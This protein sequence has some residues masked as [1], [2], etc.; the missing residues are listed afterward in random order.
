M[1][2]LTTLLTIIITSILLTGCGYTEVPTSYISADYFATNDE[3]NNVR[4]TA[5]SA[6]IVAN[7]NKIELLWTN[8]NPVSNFDSQTINVKLTPGKVYFIT[9]GINRESEVNRFDVIGTFITNGDNYT[10][11]E[12]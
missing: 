7:A 6:G 10:F 4:Q 5:I 12:I 9:Y 8:P 3:L 11:S 2:K 1:K